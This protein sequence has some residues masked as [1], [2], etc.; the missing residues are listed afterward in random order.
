M[1][2]QLAVRIEGIGA[3]TRGA[4]DWPSLRTILRGG[5]DL[6]GDAP[7]HPA[8]AALP[9]AERRRAPYGVLLA[10]EIAGQACAMA[11]RDPSILPCVFASTQGELAITDYMCAMLASTPRELS[12]TRFHNSVHNAPAG[13]WTIATQ[14]IAGSSAISAYHTTFGAGLLEAAVLCAAEQTPVL[15]A[16]YDTAAIGPL[17]GIARIAI[18]FGTALLLSPSP[19]DDA[20]RL[21][22]ALRTAPDPGTLPN[23]AS[24]GLQAL[25]ADHPLSAHALVLLA[26]LAQDAPSRLTL[27]AA[28]GLLLDMEIHL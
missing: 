11:G 6:R 24:P 3:W 15:F 5:Q 4:P 8:A 27:P 13:Y 14:C 26:A 19:D 20:P 22:V 9:A 12:P 16:A 21:T 7:Q 18:P 17:V 25:A 23:F 2:A 1:S 28:S 10:A